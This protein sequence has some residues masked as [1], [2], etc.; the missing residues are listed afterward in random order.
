[1]APPP[2]LHKSWNLLRSSEKC[3]YLNLNFP[4][5]LICLSFS[6]RSKNE[7]LF[8]CIHH[9]YTKFETYSNFQKNYLSELKFSQDHESIH[10]LHQAS[11]FYYGT[12]IIFKQN[13]EYVQ[14][15]QKCSGSCTCTFLLQVTK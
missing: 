12:S 13:L 15:S 8:W 5:I 9:F 7:I 4:R 11:H 6:K 2:F 1:M 10:T 14:F 3:T